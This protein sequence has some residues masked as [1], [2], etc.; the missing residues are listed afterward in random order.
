MNVCSLEGW[1]GWWMFSAGIL[2]LFLKSLG[3]I[4]C[5]NAK[6]VALAVKPLNGVTLNMQPC[7]FTFCYFSAM[8]CNGKWWPLASLISPSRTCSWIIIYIDPG[9]TFRS[10]NQNKGICLLLMLSLGLSTSIGLL[11][12]YY[13]SLIWGI[14]YSCDWV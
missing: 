12:N 11:S 7:C 14:I 13:S 3:F 6:F 1:Y 2:E 4:S 9:T 8:G 10:A 5:M